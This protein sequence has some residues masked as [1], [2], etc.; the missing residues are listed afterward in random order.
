MSDTHELKIWP[1]YYRAVADGSKTFEVRVFDRDYRV[2]DY[3]LLREWLPSLEEYTGE[4]ARVEV[5][6]LYVLPFSD[7]GT[8]YVVM[9]IRRLPA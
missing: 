9:S 3:L 8:R 6:Y 7:N 5:T 1:E 2:G 4:E